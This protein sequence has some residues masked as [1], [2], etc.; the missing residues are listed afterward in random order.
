MKK[1]TKRIKY[2][3]SQEVSFE[4]DYCVIGVSSN[5]PDYKL[6]WSL[7]EKLDAKFDR[8]EALEVFDEQKNAMSELP[9]FMW[10]PYETVS[11][12]LCQPSAANSL[13][14][15]ALII[16][17]GSEKEEN[18]NSFIAR[19]EALTEFV[20]FVET[21]PLSTNSR[22]KKQKDYIKSINNLISELEI[23][24]VS[25]KKEDNDDA[26]GIREKRITPVKLRMPNRPI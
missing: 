19:I 8:V 1:K 26:L 12:F 3:P 5:L 7:N 15:P 2:I 17:Q 18:I 23:H 25:L 6:A 11:Y 13:F 16:I 4:K 10:N 14:N 20:S 9:L 22:N 24:A 21:I